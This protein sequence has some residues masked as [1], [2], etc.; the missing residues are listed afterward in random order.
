MLSVLLWKEYREHRIVWAALAFVAAASLLFLPVVMAPGGLESHPDVRNLLRTMIIVLSWTYGLICG[1]MLLAGEREVGTLSFL[2]AL[3]GLRWRLWAAKCLAGL[4]LVFSQIVLMMVTAT[5][6]HLFAS[7]AEAAWTL[8]GMFWSGLYGFAWGMLFS[9]F[10]RSVMN[11]IL[12]ALAAQF[13]AFFV[14][15][16]LAGF[17]AALSSVATGSPRRRRSLDHCSGPGRLRV[18]LHTSGPRPFAASPYHDGADKETAQS[19]LVGVVLADV[20]AGARFRLG[21]GDFW[22]GYWIFNTRIRGNRLAGGN[23]LFRDDVRRNRFRRRAAR[24]VSLSRRSTAATVAALDRQGRRPLGHCAGGRNHNDHAGL[25]H[26][27]GQP[28]RFAADVCGDGDYGRAGIVRDD[29]A[30]LRLLRRRFVQLTVSQPPG[31]CRFFA[32]YQRSSGGDM[33]A[34]FIGKRFVRLATARAAD[35]VVRVH[36]VS[37]ASV[38]GGPNRLVDYG[39]TAYSVRRRQRP[40]DCGR[41]MVSGIGDTQ[42]PR[43]SGLGGGSGGS[44]H[45]EGEQSRRTCAQRLQAVWR[46]GS[47]AL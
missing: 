26:R 31:V 5:A 23:A 9:S 37:L 13:A 8:N 20:A 32:V 40:L 12:L 22:L 21:Y 33:V 47:K 28:G 25:L 45:G 7:G 4:L 30:C 10:G 34:F 16:L 11:M 17:L 35:P 46:P 6:T 19:W 29:G 38:G 27:Y 2:D 43:S 14:T 3:P 24:A 44:A 39:Q 1:A 42:C 36:A 18:S 15:S 41:L